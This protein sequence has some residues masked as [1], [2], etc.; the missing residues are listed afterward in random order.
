MR[1]IQQKN[2]KSFMKILN[3][4]I[5]IYQI[6]FIIKKLNFSILMDNKFNKKT[7]RKFAIFDRKKDQTIDA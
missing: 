2:Q 1:A 4:S 3:F 7:N 6:M 5:N